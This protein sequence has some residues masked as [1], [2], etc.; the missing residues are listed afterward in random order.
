MA[1]IQRLEPY[2]WWD[3][4]EEVNATSMGVDANG[5][6]VRYT[7][8]KAIVDQLKEEV[9]RLQGLLITETRW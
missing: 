7:D 8:H 3:S 1:D 9:A 2:D 5:D 6:Y 4:E